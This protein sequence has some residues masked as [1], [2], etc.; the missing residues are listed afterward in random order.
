VLTADFCEESLDVVIFE[1]KSTAKHDIKNNTSTPDVDLGPCIQTTSNDLGSG[2]IGTATTCL[3]K[4][5]VLDLIGEAKIGDFNIE[6]IIEEH[7]LR[8]QI[9]MDDLEAMR[10]LDA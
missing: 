10:V 6:I 5:P 4:I 3:E 9:T 7:I 1:R 2:I 8:F